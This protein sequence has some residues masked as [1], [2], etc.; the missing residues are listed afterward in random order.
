M[1]RYADDF[2]ILTDSHEEAEAALALVAVWVSENGLTLHPT[3]TK[4]VARIWDR[5]GCPIPA[6]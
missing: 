5:S 4:V 1:V 6:L 2:V 3:K